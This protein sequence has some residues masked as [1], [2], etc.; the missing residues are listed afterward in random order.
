MKA[1]E[2]TK[3]KT[4]Y[5]MKYPTDEL[6]DEINP[7]ATFGSLFRAM[8]NYEHVYHHIGVFDSFVREG[9]FEGLCEVTGHTYKE[10]HDQWLKC[11]I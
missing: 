5:I 6:G 3:L 1:T 9:I 4:W 10:I 7:E 2:N 11:E 8:D